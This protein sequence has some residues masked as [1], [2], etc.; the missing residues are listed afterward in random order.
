MP[1]LDY[2]QENIEKI[3]IMFIS[4][5]KLVKGYKISIQRNDLFIEGTTVENLP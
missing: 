1:K 3:N 5:I 2:R 4:N